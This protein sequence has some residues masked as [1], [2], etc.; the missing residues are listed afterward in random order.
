MALDFGGTKL[1]AAVV[2]ISRGS[3]VESLRRP[4]PAEHSAEASIAAMMEMGRQLVRQASRKRRRVGAVGVSFGG[5]VVADHGS[6]V[7][8]N[9][10]AG[11]ESVSLSSL[12]SATF[13]LPVIVENDA[14]AAA[15]CEWRFGAAR[16]QQHVLYLQVSTGIGVGLILG[17]Q[18]YRGAGAAGEFGHVIVDANGPRCACGGT[19]CVES[20]ASGWAIERDARAAIQRD[21]ASGA[22]LGLCRGQA[23]DLDARLVV[24]AAQAGDQIADAIL[25]RAFGS[26]GRALRNAI[27]L[28]DPEVVVVGG[29]VAQAG[30][31]LVD[32]LN[33]EIDRH[34]ERTPV[35]R[36]SI[37]LA[38]FVTDAPLIGAAILAAEA[39]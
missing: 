13:E 22:M 24:Q 5:P 32:V 27:A 9:H 35:G 20:I 34:S 23:T 25:G 16:G 18:L 31:R 38:K 19:G 7:H 15:I 12:V 4:T 28:I 37:R 17:G 2:D 36:P 1:A 3:V 39:N 6:G 8:S 30:S 33:A 26:L 14:N 21:G 29:G 11:W 10:V